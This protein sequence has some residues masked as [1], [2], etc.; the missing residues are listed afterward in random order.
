MRYTKS[1]I[2]AQ[3]EIVS[4][5]T[6]KDVRV[7]SAY[8]GHGVHLHSGG[9]QTDLMGGCQSAKEASRFLSGMIAAAELM[10]R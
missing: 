9:G 10:T 7:Y 8:G 2:E 4:S 6:G 5:L 1:M 3:A